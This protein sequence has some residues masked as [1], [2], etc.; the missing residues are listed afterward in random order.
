MTEYKLVLSD[1][2]RDDLEIVLEE[3]LQTFDF[4][5]DLTDMQIPVDKLLELIKK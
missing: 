5:S 1:K 3:V 2:E 4:H